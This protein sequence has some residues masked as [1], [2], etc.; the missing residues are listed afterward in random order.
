MND[1]ALKL[2]SINLNAYNEAIKGIFAVRGFG[3]GKNFFV[4]KMNIGLKPEEYVN[5]LRLLVLNVSSTFKKIAK[6]DLD[7]IV[8][9]LDD[10]YLILRKRLK[11]KAEPPLFL[12]ILAAKSEGLETVDTII[13]ELAE[14]LFML[15]R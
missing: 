6:D 12:S 11:T 8:F 10:Y 7:K 4:G 14:E 13:E 3:H 9:E 5:S 1:S 15:L 2:I